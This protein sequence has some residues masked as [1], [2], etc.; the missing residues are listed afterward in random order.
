MITSLGS[1]DPTTRRM[2][3]Q[4][5]AMEEEHANDLLGILEHLPAK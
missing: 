5:L 3:E 4:I 2:L 1:N